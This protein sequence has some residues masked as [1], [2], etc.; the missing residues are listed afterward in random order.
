VKRILIVIGAFLL[1]L[2]AGMRSGHAQ[3][4]A[5]AILLGQVQALEKRV[6]E[7]ESR[8]APECTEVREGKWTRYEWRDFAG[9]YILRSD[10]PCPAKE[11]P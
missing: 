3:N 2:A 10:T 5:D 9:R 7:L 6:T 11:K 4:G 8:L 1:L